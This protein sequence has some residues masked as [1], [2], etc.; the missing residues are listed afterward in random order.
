MV[1][2]TFLLIFISIFLVMP[3]MVMAQSEPEESF[4]TFTIY[5]ENDYFAGT[6]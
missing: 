2:R 4:D 6:D 1:M 5:V 3:E